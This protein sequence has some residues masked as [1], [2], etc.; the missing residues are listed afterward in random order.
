[1][2]G[3]KVRRTTRQVLVNATDFKDHI[4][5]QRRRKLVLHSPAYYLLHAGFSLGLL[6]NPDGGGDKFLRKHR[7]T[8]NGL[9]GLILLKTELFAILFIS[10][11]IFCIKN[12]FAQINTILY[13]ASYA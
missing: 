13:F 3:K 10:L 5:C 12:I 1:M 9:H 8:L 4:L 11:C 2:L 6:F 7:L